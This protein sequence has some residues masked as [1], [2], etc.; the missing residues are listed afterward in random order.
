[1]ITTEYRPSTEKH[2]YLQDLDLIDSGQRIDVSKKDY[3]FNETVTTWCDYLNTRYHPKSACVI[4]DSLKTEVFHLG[5]QMYK[6]L[7][8]EFEDRIRSYMEECDNL[9]G[10]HMIVDAVD[11]FG[12]LGNS[13]LHH[14]QDEYSTKDVMTFA[15]MPSYY[16]DPN[17]RQDVHRMI[18][19]F[20]SFQY[21]AENS[22][23]LV[24]L[25][26]NETAWR[27]LGSPLKFSNLI[28]DQ[29]VLYQTSAILSTFLDTMS[30]SYRLRND[31]TCMSDILSGLT[32][33][34]RKVCAASINLPFPM[35]PGSFLLETLEAMDEA[36]SMW[37]CLTPS[38][39]INKSKI[40]YQSISVRGI[41]IQ[42]LRNPETPAKSNNLSYTC[43]TIKE[44][45]Q[46]YL[47]YCSSTVSNV[48]TAATPLKTKTPFPQIF[49]PHVSCLGSVD[50]K[51]TRA[52]GFD[53]MSC[54]MLSG[55][56]SAKDI[57]SMLESLY[58][59]VKNVNI[60]RF[61]HFQD[62][63]MDYDEY[64]ECLERIENMSYAYSDDMEFV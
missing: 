23:I 19:T 49:S 64:K 2:E 25:S 46:L 20:L 44:L 45:V 13:I 4:D 56:H 15:T 38:C 30:L 17:P 5:E 11:G 32:F 52:E 50:A 40:Y 42:R 1:M 55:L 54:P 47:S 33:S 12:G 61:P 22:S 60:K 58:K 39:N 28:Y 62:S 34:N 51:S 35:I 26:T 18:N 10:F 14:L 43:T 9:Q 21:L 59:N 3:K 48:T 63:G 57:G 29:K 7:E 6:V 27:S 41:P 36:S 24:P 8:N 16:Q 31:R 53:V 37:S